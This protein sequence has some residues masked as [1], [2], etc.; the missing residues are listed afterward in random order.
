MRAF[1]FSF[2][3][4]AL[5][6]LVHLV[7][8][9]IRRPSGQYAGL[10]LLSGIVLGLSLASLLFLSSASQSFVSFIPQRS[11]EYVSFVCLYVLL[12]VSYIS[13]YSAIQADS[14]SFAMLLMIDEAGSRGVSRAELEATLTDEVLV[15][16]RVNDLVSGGLAKRAGDRYIIE[17]GGAAFARIHMAYRRLLKLERGG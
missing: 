4:F 8:W 12:G 6:V 1:L 7:V 10:L 5:L 15:I 2:L 3:A 17:P 11:M 9:R 13:T 14:P 16:P